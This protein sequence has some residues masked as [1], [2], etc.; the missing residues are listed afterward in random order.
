MLCWLLLSACQAPKDGN[1][2]PFTTGPSET[3]TP[4]LDTPTGTTGT[5]G[6][7]GGAT[8]AETGTDACSVL[9]PVPAPF[10]SLPQF[11]TGEDFDIDIDGFLCST[12]GSVADVGNLACRD[13]YGETKVIA[14]DV[15]NFATGTRV[16]ST[17]DWAINDVS[18]GSLVRVEAAT[19]VRHVVSSGFVTA[20]GLETDHDGY[21]YVAELSGGHIFQVDPYTGERWVVAEDL[22]APNGIALSPDEQTLYTCT[23]GGVGIIAIDRIAEHEWDVPRVLLDPPGATAGFDGL[24]VDSCGNV[25]V[26]EPSLGRIIRVTP[27][28]A[29][30][31]LLVDL[32]QSWIPNLHFGSGQAGW[33]STSLYVTAW[34][35]VFEV[36]VGIPGKP[37]VQLP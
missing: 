31:D 14:V 2:V 34:S 22:M 28:G 5:T 15:T 6:H 13:M 27:D 21:V 35:E 17:G 19:G 33:S 20:N 9:P 37:H 36:Q 29:Q 11:Q 12:G 16:L 30:V 26:T 32:P 25:Y 23:F 8:T 24:E 7:T 10:V 1:S 4:G 3:T 18:T